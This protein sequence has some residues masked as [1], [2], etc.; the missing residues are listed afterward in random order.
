M[1]G[2]GCCCAVYFSSGCNTWAPFGVEL[3][4][5]TVPVAYVSTA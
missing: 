1:M 4:I 5:V 2:A 3:L